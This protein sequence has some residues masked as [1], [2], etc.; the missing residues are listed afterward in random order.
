VWGSDPP[1]GRRSPRPAHRNGGEGPEAESPPEEER[2]DDRD[3]QNDVEPDWAP[4]P[5]EIV[6]VRNDE[7]DAD[8][9]ARDDE[10]VEPVPTHEPP[11]GA[12]ALKV[13]RTRRFR[14]VRENDPEIVP[15]GD[16]KRD[17]PP[18]AWW[19]ERRGD[20]RTEEAVRG[21]LPAPR[22]QE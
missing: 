6:L 7:G 2:R 12:H 18:V 4:R 13:L 3:H 9:K 22:T 11:D 1:V 15:P 8:A 20:L 21:P 19:H 14:L 16:G 10:R 5:P 17:S